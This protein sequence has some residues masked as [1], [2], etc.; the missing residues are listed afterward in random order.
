VAPLVDY[1]RAA[2]VGTAVTSAPPS[3]LAALLDRFGDY[4]LTERGL[5]PRTTGR[6]VV[7]ARAFLTRPDPHLDRADLD[8]VNPHLGQVRQQ[9]LK[10]V[11]IAPGSLYTVDDHVH[12]RDELRS[13]K[14]GQIQ[15][16]QANIAAA[17][18]AAR[19][20]HADRGTSM[21]SKPVAL[22][23]ADLGVLRSHSRP[24]VSPTAKPRSNLEVLP[25]LPRPV[26]VDRRRPR[27]LRPVP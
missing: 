13:T 8:S 18:V 16:I 21:T 15:F 12:G 7:L 25:G 4:L 26:R 6:Y 20:V 17:G 3:Q 11:I 23:L 14:A 24:K 10:T 9:D 19:V 1:L 22:L 2:G 5:D 27:F